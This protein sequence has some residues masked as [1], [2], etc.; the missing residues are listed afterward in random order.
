[1]AWLCW[2]R[3]GFRRPEAKQ[4]RKEERQQANTSNFRSDF[5]FLTQPPT[6]LPLG[7]ILEPV[8]GTALCLLVLLD[9]PWQLGG[10]VSD[11]EAARPQTVIVAPHSELAVLQWK[12]RISNFHESNV[13]NVW[14]WQLRINMIWSLKWTLHTV[15]S[16]QKNIISTSQ[17]FFFLALWSF[18][19]SHILRYDYVFFQTS[20]KHPSFQTCLY[21]T[22][23][24][25]DPDPKGLGQIRSAHFRRWRL[26]G[27]GREQ[28]GE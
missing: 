26:R 24:L 8:G 11:K 2:H 10:D 6:L 20:H 12:H 28:G 7:E 15:F 13:V 18:G 14:K 16:H 5:F 4:K 21:T 27:G 9:V 19:T 1:M 25:W 17:S 23:C 3:R 22:I